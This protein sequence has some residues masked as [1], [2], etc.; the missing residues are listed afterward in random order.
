MKIKRQK[1]YNQFLEI[2]NNYEDVILIPHNEIDLDALGSSVGLYVFLE[3]LG[4]KTYINIDEADT[5]LGVKRAIQKLKDLNMNLDIK[6]LKNIDVNVNTLLIILDHHKKEMSQNS[7]I[8]KL[9]KNLI[10]IDHHIEG[11]ESIN[12]CLLKYIDNEAS[13]TTEIVFDLLANKKINIPNYIA[14]IMLA[15]LTLDTNNFTIKTN[16][17]THEVAAKLTK[18]GAMSKEVQYLLKE[19]LKQYI[20]M[21]KI[22]FNTEIIN[23]IYAIA[24]G[25]KT[26][27]YNKEQLAK[28]SDSL[29]QFDGIEASFCIGKIN[30]NVIGISARSLG[31]VNVQKIMEK[32][33]GGGHVT[34]AACQIY[35]TSLNEAKNQLLKIIEKL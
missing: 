8:Y 31:D 4:K 25:K 6:P 24:V 22:I 34:D 18:Q 30:T 14:T 29:L 32:L 28:I 17:K 7:D 2:L 33:N 13:S 21:Q 10:I 27:I 35:N 19:D 20:N 23:G 3:G 16:E 5:E 12:N 1:F 11:K 9:S 26:E 15:G